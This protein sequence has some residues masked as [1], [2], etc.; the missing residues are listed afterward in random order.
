MPGNKISILSVARTCVKCARYVCG[1]GLELYSGIHL[2]TTLCLG[3]CPIIASTGERAR[4]N[5]GKMA[6]RI[7]C[8]VFF[9][10]VVEP[11]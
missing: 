11:P 2:H 8:K 1:N 4:F 7:V 10:M 9:I 5:C 6:F 3:F